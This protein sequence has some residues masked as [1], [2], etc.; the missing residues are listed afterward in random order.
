MK[1][2]KGDKFFSDIII[3]Y[4]KINKIKKKLYKI[5]RYYGKN[6]NFAVKYQESI[7]I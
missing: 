5:E 3:L 7:F 1:L 4:K 2:Q 6:E